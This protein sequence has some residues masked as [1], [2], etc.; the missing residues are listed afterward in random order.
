MGKKLKWRNDLRQAF[1]L[2]K[3]G[4]GGCEI[5]IRH[6]NEFAMRVLFGL[7]KHTLINP[8]SFIKDRNCIGHRWK[9]GYEGEDG[10]EV[11][12]VISKNLDYIYLFE[13]EVWK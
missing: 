1:N 7:Y 2:G 13:Y 11:N 3:E 4:T 6:S 12:F 5:N 10:G 9:I 8:D